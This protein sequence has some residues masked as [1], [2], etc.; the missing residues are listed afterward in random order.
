MVRLK[1]QKVVDLEYFFEVMPDFL[2]VVGFD[3]HFVKINPAVCSVL[4]YTEDE[5]IGS[6]VE[7]FIHPDDVERT[8]EKQTELKEGRSLLNF[9]NRYLTKGGAVVWLS[10][11]SVPIKKDN[12]IF[13][14][15]KDITYRRQLEEYERISSI[16][17]MINDDHY[18]RFKQHRPK[19]NRTFVAVRSDDG[20][21][22]VEEPSQSDQFWLNSLETVVRQSAGKTAVGLGSDRIR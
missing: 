13:A 6:A 17:G 18:T 9:E 10:W 1:S 16:L 15:G 3:G 14:I 5:L 22:P 20:Q 8:A 4:G 11:T 19:A 21:K 2:C 12:Q 7:D